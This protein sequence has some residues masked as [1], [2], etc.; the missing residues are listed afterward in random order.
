MASPENFEGRATI[1]RRILVKK[2]HPTKEA[3]GNNFFCKKLTT[4][5]SMM[6]AS[7]KNKFY[8]QQIASVKN[9]YQTA[10]MFV[11]LHSELPDPTQLYLE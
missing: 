9:N 1:Q 7:I 6:F 11:K 2:S 5:S 3:K 8:V 10:C 4:L